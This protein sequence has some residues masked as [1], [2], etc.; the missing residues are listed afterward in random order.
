[1]AQKKTNKAAGDPIQFELDAIK[2]LLTLFLIKAGAPQGEIAMA[3]DVDQSVVSRMFSARK[4]Q[5]F[6][7]VK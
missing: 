3:L 5:K 2:R 7:N 6:D 4:V 1:M